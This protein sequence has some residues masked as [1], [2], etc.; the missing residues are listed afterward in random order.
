MISRLPKIRASMEKA[1]VPSPAIATSMVIAKI[2]ELRDSK[3]FGEQ[4]G[5]NE[6]PAAAVLSGQSRQSASGSRQ[7]QDARGESRIGVREIESPLD[8]D[9]CARH[10]TQQKQ[11][12]PSPAAREFEEKASH[13]SNSRMP[14]KRRNS[15]C[16]HDIE[17]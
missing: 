2:R 13:W 6:K 10:H 1:P 12:S 5:S 14:L 11:G 17:S 3:K 8:N 15:T 16:C 7:E 9:R 4:A